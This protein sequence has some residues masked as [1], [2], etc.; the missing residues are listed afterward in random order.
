MS[1]L[2]D[3]PF[4][5]THDIEPITRFLLDTYRLYGRPFNWEPRRW[6]GTVYHRND[7]EMAALQMEL[8]GRVH[9][10]LDDGEIVGMVI[11]ESTASVFLQIN[12]A[13]RSLERTM[14]DWAEGHLPPNIEVWAESNDTWRT[15]LL[16][17]RDYVRT[18]AH[19]ILR[20]R[21][22][23]MPTPS[24]PVPEGYLQRIMRQHTDDQQG[25]AALLNAAFDR[26]FHS[27]EE[28][29]NFQ[30]SPNYRAD[31][32]IVVEAP[33]GSLA[34]NVGVTVFERESFA[35]F[36]PV[37]THPHHQGKGLARCAIAEGLRR[38]GAME[39]EAAFIGAWY[40][41][42]VSN[43]LYAQMGFTESTSLYLWRR[44]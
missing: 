7:V 25:M 1:L 16:A 18:E 14:L 5:S 41:N 20:R 19:E 39:I 40:A 24:I 38:V 8:Q 22:M 4:D 30:M 11:V 32:D 28:Y 27:A 26:T 12:P 21:D 31:L 35:V 37:C 17:E 34:A 13:Y 42:P 43:H 15:G 10:W 3:R 23:S 9:L 44:G 2:A 36:E 6:H 29:R 33:D